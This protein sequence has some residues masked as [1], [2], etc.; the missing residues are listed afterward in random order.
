MT[1]MEYNGSIAFTRLT[2]SDVDMIASKAKAE[3]SGN[4]KDMAYHD[5]VMALGALGE[6]HYKGSAEWLE[7]REIETALRSGAKKGEIKLTAAAG[8]GSGSGNGDAATPMMK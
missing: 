4:P 1:N 2:N 8:G 3:G 7:R 6:Q 5:F